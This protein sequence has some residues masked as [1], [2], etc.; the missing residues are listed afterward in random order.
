MRRVLL[1]RKGPPDRLTAGWTEGNAQGPEDET[2]G[3]HS[4]NSSPPIPIQAVPFPGS[5]RTHD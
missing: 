1:N 3:A 2:P 5:R 4:Q